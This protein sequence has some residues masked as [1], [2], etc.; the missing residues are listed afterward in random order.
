MSSSRG[1]WAWT[2]LPGVSSM[3]ITKFIKI[4]A[5]AR[6]KDL[7]TGSQRGGT[8]T[9]GIVSCQMQERKR[10]LGKKKDT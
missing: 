8:A 10:G 2:S 6:P 5:V 4:A 3:G 9:V 7:S 1:K